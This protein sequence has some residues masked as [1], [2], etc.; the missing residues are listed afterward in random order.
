MTVWG[1]VWSDFGDTLSKYYWEIE[2]CLKVEKSDSCFQV[3]KANTMREWYRSEVTEGHTETEVKLQR[4]I[5]RESVFRWY[6][7]PWFCKGTWPHLLNLSGCGKRAC[8]PRFAGHQVPAQR[9]SCL[10]CR[11]LLSRGL[12]PSQNGIHSCL[13][14]LSLKLFSVHS[15]LLWESSQARPSEPCHKIKP[16]YTLSNSNIP[17]FTV[18]TD[19]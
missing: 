16:I 8:P 4:D 15:G 5:P 11:V 6:L 3:G 12:T 18:F 9:C 10:K 1:S 19:W 13:L 2:L 14:F 7:N 17:T